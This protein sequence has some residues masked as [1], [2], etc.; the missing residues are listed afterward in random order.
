MERAVVNSSNL[1]AVGY[2]LESAILEVEF[3]HGG[4]YQYFGVPLLVYQGLLSAAS[5]GAYLNEI[6]KRGG[7]RYS[8]VADA[9]PAKA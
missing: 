9:L 4:I 2:S 1:A 3:R 6:V 7:Y 8:R 5:K